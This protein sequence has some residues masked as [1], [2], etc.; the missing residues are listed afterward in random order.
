LL[1][2][3]W[4][5]AQMDEKFYYPAKGW[6]PVMDSVKHRE[7]PFYIEKDTLSTVLFQPDTKKVKATIVYFHGA[8]G[9]ISRYLQFVRPLINA[10]YQLYM[11]DFRGYGKSTGKPTHLNIAKDAAII[12]DSALHMK[13]IANTKIVVYG[14]SIGSQIA[15][16]IA[17]EN[18]QK[19][20]ALVLDGTI[21]SFTD[22]AADS[23]PEQQ[24]EMIRGFLKSPYSAKE[25]IKQIDNIPVLFIHSKE[26]KDVPISEGELVF[27]NAP[28]PKKEMWIYTGGHIMAGKLYPDEMVKRIDKLIK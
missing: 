5:L 21:A 14:T 4:T 25:S 8:G 27:Q 3:Q 22:I 12:F 19:I 9:N 7:I 28:T 17:A 2:S 26:D 16:K 15:T 1:L 10:G 18:K 20:T 23:S 6:E 24:R 11:V 13:E